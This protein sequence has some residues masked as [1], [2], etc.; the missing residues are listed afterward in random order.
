[1]KKNIVGH[2]VAPREGTVKKIKSWGIFS[3]LLCLLL[4][5]AIW[6][7]IV[8]VTKQDPHDGYQNSVSA[9]ETAGK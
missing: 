6:L 5:L 8:D 4:A 2:M 7:L 9:T 3:K 1:M